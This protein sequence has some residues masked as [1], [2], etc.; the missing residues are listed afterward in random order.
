[1]ALAD[2]T[3]DAGLAPDANPTGVS[4]PE[5]GLPI[6]DLL[7]YFRSWEDGK[8]VEIREQRTA[9]RYYHAKQWTD[10]E[11]KA[12]QDRG[13]PVVTANR[14]KTEINTLVGLTVRL[15]SDP[16]AY[17]RRP[18]SDDQAE[19]ATAV[20]RYV[21]ENN[22]WDL[23]AEQ[24][25][26][27]GLVS[28]IGAVAITVKPKNGREEVA[29][30]YINVDRFFYDPRSEREDFSDARYLGVH[31]WMDIGEAIELF[32]Q[33]ADEIN[34]IAA[35]ANHGGSGSTPFEQDKDERWA[36]L[37]N[38]RVR[39]VE[40]YYKNRG[41]WWLCIFSGPYKL[42][43]QP[44]PYVDED[45]ESDHPY[46]PW[47]PYIDEEGIRYGVVRDMI[48]PQDEINKRRSKLLHELNS[49]QIKVGN[50]A[51]D[52]IEA[53]RREAAR[54]D[55][56]L[57]V[58]KWD[59]FD[60]VDRRKEIA[61][62]AELLQEAKS[63]LERRGPSPALQGRGSP[64]QSGRALRSEQDSGMTEL[65]PVFEFMRHWK[66]RV[67]RK[68]WARIRQA[69][70]DERY[71]RI[72]QGGQRPAQSG[73]AEFMAVNQQ[74]PDPASGQI[75]RRNPIAKIDVDIILDEGPDV[76]TLQEEEFAQLSN[77]ASSGVPIPPDVLIEASNLRNKDQLLER[78]RQPQ[79]EQEQAMQQ[80]QMQLQVRRAMHEIDEIMSKSQKNRAGA[81]QDLAGADKEDLE[82]DQVRQFG[83]PEM[84]SQ[85]RQT[86]ASPNG[87][88]G[89]ARTS[90]RTSGRSPAAAGNGR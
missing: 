50:G 28:G 10:E 70:T 83:A 87:Q 25:A 16:K 47:S 52:D 40:M 30:D 7:R 72:T 89:Q 14:I 79:S 56:V 78:M 65:T 81:I 3:G 48:S 67:Y 5:A 60:F 31:T 41:K 35:S 15:R 46:E 59:E 42:A 86:A 84:A 13:Q 73:Q 69:W 11:K 23:L 22:R 21:A 24:C 77:M 6:E 85:T 4:E 26:S 44:S 51:V 12:L 38:R 1:M 64:M 8:D 17:P 45:G 33:R 74:Q 82:A 20:L 71:I 80:L 76:M 63:E 27:D 53:T 43:E 66:I 75:I 57:Q 36:D 39:L 2:V 37:T 32:P 9:R 18:D 49:R 54:A 61:G 55:G 90:S 58:N 19:V 88:G 29:L 62:Q 68:M 34:A